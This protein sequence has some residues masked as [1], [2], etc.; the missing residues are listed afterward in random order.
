M[1]CGVRFPIPCMLSD[2]LF[3]LTVV[4]LQQERE[5][6]DGTFDCLVW[7]LYRLRFHPSTTRTCILSCRWICP[8]LVSRGSR[9]Y[10]WYQSGTTPTGRTWRGLLCARSRDLVHRNKS[11]RCRLEQPSSSYTECIYWSGRHLFERL[12]NRRRWWV[13]HGDVLSFAWNDYMLVRTF[14]RVF[15]NPSLYPMRM[16]YDHLPLNS[17]PTEHFYLFFVHRFAARQDRCSVD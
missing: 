14:A 6:L 16:L 4:S 15:V 13:T 12:A 10:S 8:L 3:D 1:R 9:G 17:D 11:S 2:V 7:L 5:R